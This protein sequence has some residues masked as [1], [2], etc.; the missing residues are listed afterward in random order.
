MIGDVPSPTATS[1]AKAG[2]YSWET[3]SFL[4]R[5]VGLEEDEGEGRL[6]GV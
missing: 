6:E 2:C 1:Y 5:K 4:R 3:S